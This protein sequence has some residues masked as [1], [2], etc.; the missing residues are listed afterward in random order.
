MDDQDAPQR[1]LTDQAPR[2]TTAGHKRLRSPVL[3]GTGEYYY[4]ETVVEDEEYFEEEPNVLRS[5]LLGSKQKL[6]D[7]QQPAASTAAPSSPAQFEA[8]SPASL[9]AN[10]RIDS[11]GTDAES[12]APAEHTSLASVSNVVPAPPMPAP[13]QTAC[14]CFNGTCSRGTLA[15]AA[16]YL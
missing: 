4:Q 14:H 2:T 10:A 5:P 9:G 6:S 11:F 15:S 13:G 7:R 3:D 16:E 12:I 8:Q 1:R